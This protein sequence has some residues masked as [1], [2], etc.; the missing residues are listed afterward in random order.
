MRRT[1][2]AVFE[3]STWIPALAAPAASAFT[4]VL[5]YLGTRRRILGEFASG[6]SARRSALFAEALELGRSYKENWKAAA[7]EV[8]ELK[9]EIQDLRTEMAEMTAT[10]RDLMA[11][12]DRWRAAN[13]DGS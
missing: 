11:E 3:P 2:V 12:V 10:I 1:I 8:A 6:D 5:V 4:G 9:Q 7:A 13:G